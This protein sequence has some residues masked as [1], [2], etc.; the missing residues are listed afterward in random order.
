MKIM[1]KKNY[2]APEIRNVVCESEEMIAVSKFQTG[3]KAQSL[4]PTDEEFGGEFQSRRNTTW[5]DEE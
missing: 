2:I 3:E 5:D 1:E 4:T